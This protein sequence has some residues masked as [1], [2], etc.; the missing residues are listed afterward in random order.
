MLRAIS[1]WFHRCVC[2]LDIEINHKRGKVV[3]LATADFQS[4]LFHKYLIRRNLFLVM[5]IVACSCTSR[6]ML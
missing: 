4:S 2:G 5:S 3:K 6:V 1:F